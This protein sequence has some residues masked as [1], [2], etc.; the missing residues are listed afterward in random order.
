MNFEVPILLLGF[1]RPALFEK[2]LFR[3]LQINPINLY[4]SLDGPRLNKTDDIENCQKIKDLV[5]SIDLP[6][7]IIHLKF[8][9][10]NLGCKE[11]PK[12]AIDWFF[13]EVE[14]GIIL[15]DDCFPS[16]SFFSF[17]EE[18][19]LKYLEEDRISHI[20]GT[21]FQHGIWRGTSSYYFS[22][23]TNI[24]GWATW[25]RAWKDFDISMKY[26]EN[27]PI[28]LK[29]KQKLP[30]ALMQD[31]FKGSNDIWDIQWYYTNYLHERLTI[32]PNINL[33]QNLGFGDSGTHTFGK[34][35]S[36]ISRT[37]NGELLFPLRHKKRISPNKFADNLVSFKV[38][39]N[40][41]FGIYSKKFHC[42]FI[43]LHR[44]VTKLKLKYIFKPPFEINY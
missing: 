1:N 12:S 32:I 36:Y 9:D 40:N 3:I 6:G 5:A 37:P 25:R 26:F 34:I 21:N 7:C 30:F 24:W 4:I 28:F 16:L 23:H 33:V 15:E 43:I 42:L 8:S 39:G 38:F 29:N 20:S 41:N 2:T 14:Y 35:Y 27:S 13:S 22:Q 31:V 17:C 44:F 18:L 19:L 10:I 11:A